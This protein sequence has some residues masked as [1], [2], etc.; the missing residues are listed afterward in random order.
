MTGSRPRRRPPVPTTIANAARS[1]R[2]RSAV[3]SR[4]R[5]SV[6]ATAGVTGL[7]GAPAGVVGLGGRPAAG[8]PDDPGV[9]VAPAPALGGVGR[10]DEG[11]SA[12][13]VSADETVA[14]A[15]SAPVGGWVFGMS[16]R[17]RAR[18]GALPIYRTTIL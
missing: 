12:V 11:I 10:G 18:D 14:R 13:F 9:V 15:E 17:E 8:V 2:R 4:S 7:N 16:C 5:D 6:G 3:K 1:N